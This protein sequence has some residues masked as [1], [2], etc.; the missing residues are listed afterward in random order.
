MSD[1][2]EIFHQLPQR[3][4]ILRI[5]DPVFTIE[6]AT[7]SYVQSTGFNRDDIVGKS[8]FEVFPDFTRQYKQTGI[9]DLAEVFRK[10]IRTKKPLTQRVFRYDLPDQSKPGKSIEYYWK[11]T[12]YPLYSAE[13][14]VTH[15]LQVSRDTTAE[16]L[17]DREL[18]EARLQ[19]QRNIE[20]QELGRTKNE[21]VALA[22]HQLRT[23]AT[24]VKQYLGMVLQGYV[25]PVD[26]VQEELLAKA[27]ESNER[28][29]QIINQILNA[30][31]AD[32]GKL[33]MTPEDFDLTEM[34][35]VITE[36]MRHAVEAR[37]HTFKVKLP[38][39]AI[40]LHGDLGYLR[41]AIENLINNARIY[42][43]DGGTVTV[44]LSTTRSKVKLAV[45]DTGVGIRKKDLSKL[46]AKFS[47][48][49]NELSVQA[50]GSGI[51]LYLA[52]EIVRLHQG[53]V[54]VASVSG[55]GTTFTITLPIPSVK[56]R[57]IKPKNSTILTS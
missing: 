28:Q 49:H 26:K 33:I 38:A 2:R 1:F 39:A 8:Y 51:G 22:S 52:A 7:D 15:I 56:P 55:K 5:D 19:Q 47:R 14:G 41:M 44:R 36:E 42:T 6:E 23:P 46:F 31:R 45:Q 35:R 9:S 3:K 20:L 30:A 21:F 24:A 50:G 18:R 40:H 4:I 27:F 37:G 12:H 11:T 10:V 16:V 54:D 32:T 25:G 57:A 17:A 34:V 43:A 53:A 29:I 48:I 13:G